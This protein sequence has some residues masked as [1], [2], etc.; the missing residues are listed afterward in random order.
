[1]YN[2]VTM[3]TFPNTV[4]PEQKRSPIT[5]LS[6]VLGFVLVF[7]CGILVF[8]Y[9][10]T[11]RINPVMLDQHGQRLDSQSQPEQPSPSATKAKQPTP[12]AAA[13]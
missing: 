10:T 9:I 4:E 5:P 12:P 7:F 13:H 2:G 8:V 11:K 1:M 6:I 3:Q